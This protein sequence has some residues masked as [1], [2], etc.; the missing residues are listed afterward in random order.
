MVVPWAPGGSIS[1]FARV[2]A[3]R[4][5]TEL[6]RPFPV[7]DRGGANGTIGSQH[8]SRARPDGFTL[9]PTGTST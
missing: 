4:L 1:A 7:E 2:L 9:L 8:V 3:A 6:G 5:A